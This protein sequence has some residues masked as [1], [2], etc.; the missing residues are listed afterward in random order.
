MLKVATYIG[1]SPID[2][3]GCFTAQDI[4]E[5][6]TVFS[7]DPSVDYILTEEMADMS[8]NWFRLVLEKYGWREASMRFMAGDNARF[9][10]HSW[11][12]NLA[13]DRRTA[14]GDMVAAC[15]IPAGSELTE[16][17]TSYDDDGPLYRE[18]LR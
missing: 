1:P 15:D 5:G 17:Y 13:I 16:N 10:N 12:P 2:G 6:A 18:R 9:I 11:T 4:P 7:L 8:P 14:H 3:N